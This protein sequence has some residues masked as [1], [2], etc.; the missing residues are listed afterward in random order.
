MNLL[1]LLIIIVVLFGGL[2]GGY[3]GY[4]GAATMARAVWAASG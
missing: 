1:L 3:Y 2:G 4:R